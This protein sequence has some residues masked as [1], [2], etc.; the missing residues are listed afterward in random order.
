MIRQASTHD[1]QG[2]AEAHV[3]SCVVA[4]KGLVPDDYLAA[5]TVPKRV[6]ARTDHFAQTKGTTFVAEHEGRIAGFADIGPCRDSDKNPLQTGE[7]Y[8]IYLRPEY[9]GGGFGR[10]LFERG[11]AWLVDS[12]FLD[13]TTLVLENNATAQRFYQKFGMVADGQRISTKMGEGDLVEL[14]YWMKLR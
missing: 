12:G 3:A 5:L 11:I 14:R 7:L 9:F 2:I 6:S 13:C 8:S 10:Q 4:Y 1:I